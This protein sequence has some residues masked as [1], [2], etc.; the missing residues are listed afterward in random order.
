MIQK[1]AIPTTTHWFFTMPRSGS[2][3]GNTYNY[4]ES[5]VFKPPASIAGKACKMRLVGISQNTEILTFNQPTSYYMKGLSF[6]QNVTVDPTYQKYGF[7]NEKLFF[8]FV[9]NDNRCSLIGTVLSNNIVV[10]H[11]PEILVQVPQGPTEVT[12]GF[13]T[14]FEFDA[15]INQHMIIEFTPID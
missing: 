5:Y 1:T 7:L 10:G 9:G 3:T 8:Q 13:F 14:P 12:L 4:A 11:F 6:P 2:S 15:Y